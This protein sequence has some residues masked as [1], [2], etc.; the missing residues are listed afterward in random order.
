MIEGFSFTCDGLKVEA[1]EGFNK[2]LAGWKV[3]LMADPGDLSTPGSPMDCHSPSFSG[4]D[5]R[6]L[7]SHTSIHCTPERGDRIFSFLFF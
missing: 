6:F 3:A 4:E 2:L 1:Y 5:L 7:R